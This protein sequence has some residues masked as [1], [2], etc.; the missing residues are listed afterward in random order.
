M[1][2]EHDGTTVVLLQKGREL[3]I[4]LEKKREKAGIH[5]A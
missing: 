4:R 1:I 3:N 5:E 2:W